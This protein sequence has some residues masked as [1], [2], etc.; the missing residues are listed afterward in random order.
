VETST[1]LVEGLLILLVCGSIGFG[2]QLIR[3]AENSP[4]TY[5]VAGWVAAGAGAIL[6]VVRP[7]FPRAQ[8]LAYPLGSLFPALLLGGTL[9]LASR[10]VPRW[11]LPAALVHGALRV[12]LVAAGRPGTAWVLTLAVEPLVVLAAAFLAHRATPRAGSRS[13]R[14]LAP[15]LV[16]LAALGVTHVVWMMRAGGVPP[17][18]LAMWVVAVPALFGVQLHAE[19]E[20]GRRALQR[21]RDELELRVEERTAELAR[22]NRS[23]REE[24]AERRVVEE[25]LR[26]SE[27]RYRVVSELGSDLAFGFR[28][29]FDD[30]V[31]GGW[32]TDAY[33]RITG[34]TIEELQGGNW[35]P[36][37]VPED[38]EK[39]REQFAEILAH[40]ARDLEVRL[41]A[42]SGRIV[43]VQ[44]R[45]R[46]TRDEQNSCFRV[47][48]AARDITEVRQAEEERRKLERHVLEAQRL[49]SLA[50]LA[51]G[52]AHDFNNLLMVI[53]GNIRM[54]AAELPPD[55]P[56]HARLA[57]IRTAAEHGA[58]LTEQMLVYSGKSSLAL[59]PIA[60]SH[61]VEEMA[62]LLSASVSERCRLDFEL[63]LRTP[64][65]GD[66]TQIQQVVLN[67][68]TNASEALAGGAG[69]VLVRTGLMEQDALSLAGSWGTE[70]P[71]PGSYVFLEVVDDGPGM[72][73]ATQ[74]HI[75]EPFYTTKFSGRGLGLAALLGIVRAHRGVVQVQSEVGRGTRIRVLFPEAPG[76][77]ARLDAP[78]AADPEASP[79]GTILVI[80]DQ[81]SIVEV[82][83]ILLEAAGHRVLSAVGGRAGI[84]RFRSRPQEID[85][86]LLDLTMPDT[87]GEQVLLELQ[88][89][90][91]DVRVI[92]STGHD[93]GRTAERIRARGV[94]GFVRK[95]YEPEELLEQVARALRPS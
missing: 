47:V 89:L 13:E 78:A 43:T 15:S 9:V 91:P 84:E 60:L 33:A 92:I 17:G 28:V 11:L 80:D 38:L 63:S 73:A 74:A 21:A 83:Q 55:S 86:V 94:V 8:Y 67:L 40:R 76:G 56:L 26:E 1:V 66:A 25:A 2:W 42:K 82:A 44:A 5:W 87:D 30:R 93:A 51:G 65:E 61:L 41:V 39:I 53:L 75:F 12:G 23:L 34:Y 49:E 59:K 46:I 45:L 68:V 70:S 48:G 79:R 85:A 69:T 22:T 50:V 57:R 6:L 32:V 71:A 62:D 35:L 14:L 81:D 77:M 18:L 36:L 88:Q 10:P 72:D 27:A 24:V 29:G 20:R 3:R 7:E 19:W 58:R 4:A 90:R 16:A 95:P 37:V 54:V 31:S 64:V 52:V